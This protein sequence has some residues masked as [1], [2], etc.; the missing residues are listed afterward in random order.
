MASELNRPIPHP[1]INLEIQI[2]MKL[3]EKN[4]NTP[5]TPV[6]INPIVIVLLIPS[7]LE[8]KPERSNV[9]ITENCCM[10]AIIS[11]CDTEIF[12]K[13]F[14]ISGNAEEMAV[15]VVIITD[16]DKT[17]RTKILE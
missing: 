16:T 11:I 14:A 15:P 1:T 3:W 4:G 12:G 2:K 5:A 9:I 17:A 8:M 13:L 10:V 7:F 6:K